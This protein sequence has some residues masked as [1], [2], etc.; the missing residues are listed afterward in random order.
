MS[1]K[2]NPA[3][4]FE[5]Y[6]DDLARARAFYEAVLQRPLAELPTPD[7]QMQ[8][9]AFEMN[10]EGYGASGALVKH[11]MMKPGLG[12]TVVY[13]SCLDCAQEAERAVAHGGQICIPKKSIAPYGFIAWI[14]DTE[15]NTVG[16]HSM[17]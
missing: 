12:G 15:G 14:I 8:L 5:V 11:P 9:L 10:Q 7:P 3:G 6:V 17:Q 13:F 16:L 1:A 4:W 2:S